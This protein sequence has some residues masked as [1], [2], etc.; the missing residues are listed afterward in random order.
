MT[1]NIPIRASQ[2]KDYLKEILECPICYNV[3]NDGP[4]FQCQRGHVA[5][6][7]C[8][9]KLKEC[10]ICRDPIENA[11]RCRTIEKILEK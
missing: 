4:I 8:H 3:P 6:A 11:I 10:P 1:S 2:A 5:C 7:K 9:Q